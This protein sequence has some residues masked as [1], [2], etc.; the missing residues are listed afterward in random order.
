MIALITRARRTHWGLRALLGSCAHISFQ[1]VTVAAVAA[2]A[3]SSAPPPPIDTAPTPADGE[4]ATTIARTTH[5]Q[6]AFDDSAGAR[7]AGG[8]RSRLL[9]VL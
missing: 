9:V 1:G 2:V 3:I 6:G 5:T 7:A 8:N 4:R